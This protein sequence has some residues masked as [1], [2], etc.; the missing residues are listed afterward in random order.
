[1]FP[2]KTFAGA[3]VAT[4]KKIN[5]GST[6]I[7]SG[8][9]AHPDLTCNTDFCWAFWCFLAWVSGPK[10]IPLEAL[11]GPLRACGWSLVSDEYHL[12]N[13][14]TVASCRNPIE[15]PMKQGG[16]LAA[17][18]TLLSI[19]RCSG[20]NGWLSNIVNLSSAHPTFFGKQHVLHGFKALAKLWRNN[21]IHP[22]D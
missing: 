6:H 19:L 20:G 13:Y 11:V 18:T 7:A 9:S 22:I 15:I 8:T 10:K 21:N 17:W 12:P 3:M 2:N 14:P 4:W 5:R 16:P 1:M